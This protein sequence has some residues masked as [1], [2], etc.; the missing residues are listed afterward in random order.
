MI[1]RDWL[2]T[3]RLQI[4]RKKISERQTKGNRKEKGGKYKLRKA[5]MKGDILTLNRE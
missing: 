3:S 1:S 2:F 5:N 4:L